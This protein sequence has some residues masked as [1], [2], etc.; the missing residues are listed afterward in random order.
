MRRSFPIYG[1]IVV[2][3]LMCAVFRGVVQDAPVLDGT[4]LESLDVEG[5]SSESREDD[6]GL[7]TVLLSLVVLRLSGPAEESDNVLGHLRSGSRSTVIILDQTVKENTGH[8]DGTTGEEGVVVHALTDFNASRGVDVTSEKGKDIISTTV[9]GL[10]DQ[11]KVG[12]KSTTIAGSGSLLVRVRSGEVVGKLSGALEHLAL[13]VR[14]VGI[15]DFL[16]HSADLVHGMGDTNKV[17]PGN[18]VKRVAG[19]ADFAVNLVSSSDACVIKRVEEAFVG[20]GVSRGVES[21]VAEVAGM[22]FANKGEG[23]VEM[24]V[25]SDSSNGE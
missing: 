15:L 1:Y 24:G 5:D 21:F 13:S 25:P 7:D 2:H 23:S 16:S 4:P 9:T 20:P 22:G 11:A 19:C 14:S 6:D 17:A 18:A 12:R 10:D 8:G 3:R